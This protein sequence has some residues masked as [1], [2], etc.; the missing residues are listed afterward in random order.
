[1]LK[2]LVILM[3]LVLIAT[4]T[5]AAARVTGAQIVEYGVFQKLTADPNA[6]APNSLTGEIHGVVEATLQKRT[7]TIVAAVGTSFGIRVKFLG[8]PQ[9]E[10]ITCSLRWIRPKLTDPST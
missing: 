10:M 4:H 7:E 3:P 5:Y 8:E 6:K 2:P 1:M 9:D